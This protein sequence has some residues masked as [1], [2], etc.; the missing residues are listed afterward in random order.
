MIGRLYSLWMALFITAMLPLILL[1]FL[2]DWIIEEAAPHTADI[3][4]LVG[5]LLADAFL[6]DEE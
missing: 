4:R 3:L 1:V 5:G 2:A 6:G